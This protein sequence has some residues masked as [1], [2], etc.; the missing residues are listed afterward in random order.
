M[1]IDIKAMYECAGFSEDVVG[2]TE[3][4]DD[5]DRDFGNDGDADGDSDGDRSPGD[6]EIDDGDDEELG[7][8]AELA[9]DDGIDDDNVGGDKL[10]LSVLLY[11]TSLSIFSKLQSRIR[12]FWSAINSLVA[13]VSLESNFPVR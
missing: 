10:Q 8:E 5:G 3:S 1:D 11:E 13:I 7:S 4:D 6:D 12:C 2:D 9:V